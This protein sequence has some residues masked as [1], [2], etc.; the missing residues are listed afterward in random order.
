MHNPAKDAVSQ[1]ILFYLNY[2]ISPTKTRIHFSVLATSNSPNVFLRS[3]APGLSIV[4]DGTE[5]KSGSSN[6]R[7]FIGKPTQSHQNRKKTQESLWKSE[8]HHGPGGNQKISYFPVD[9]ILFLFLFLI[10]ILF[11][12]L[13]ISE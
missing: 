9:S 1:N 8:N 10:L 4:E 5:N 6:M 7:Y 2:A 13:F 11:L 12:F 3:L